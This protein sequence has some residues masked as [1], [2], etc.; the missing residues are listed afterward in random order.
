MILSI[1]SRTILYFMG[2]SQISDIIH[3]QFFKKQINIIMYS[4]TSY[5]DLYIMILYYLSYH[6]KHNTIKML[7]VNN[8]ANLQSNLESM[9]SN[10][11]FQYIFLNW[12]LN[13]IGVDTYL[14]LSNKIDNIL[15]EQLINNLKNQEKTIL[16][17]PFSYYNENKEI[18]DIL[19]NN[20]KFSSMSI[21]L[22][23]EK[24]IV[25]LSP[26]IPS[27]IENE[28]VNRFLQHYISN[29]VPI[30]PSNVKFKIRKHNKSQVTILNFKR[31]K[32]LIVIVSL[33]NIFVSL[34]IMNYSNY[35]SLN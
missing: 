28:F 25:K 2:W 20:V 33:L 18:Y 31:L 15:I 32:V 1:I 5:I 14:S 29:I 3:Q 30:N 6:R 34:N 13:N 4:N 24:K 7:L 22:D 12:I 26:E 9:P 27:I 23:Y 11:N 35:F 8:H 19:K 10:F 17:I 16:L 21:G